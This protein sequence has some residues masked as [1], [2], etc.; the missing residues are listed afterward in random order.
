MQEEMTS[1][2]VLQG[3]QRPLEGLQDVTATP[4]QPLCRLMP[5]AV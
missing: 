3:K 4:S 5:A 2:S 1:T